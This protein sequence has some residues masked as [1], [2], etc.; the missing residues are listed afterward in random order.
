M[1]MIIAIGSDHAGFEYK[2]HLAQYLRA[3]GHTIID[4]GT[5][6]PASVDYPDFAVRTAHAVAQHDA[7]YGVLVCGSGIGVAMTANKVQGIRAANCVTTE[8][9]HLARQHNNANIVTIGQRLVTR[10]IAE[11]IV[12]AFLHTEFEGGRHEGRVAKIHVLTGC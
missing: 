7:D 10:D 1:T 8:M 12:T 3:Q 5:D 4:F 11:N 6:S 9:A 2:Q